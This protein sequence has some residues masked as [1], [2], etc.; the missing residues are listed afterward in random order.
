MNL[1]S[2]KI[3]FQNQFSSIPRYKEEARNPEFQ[4]GQ[5]LNL[6]FNLITKGDKVLY[7][8][9]TTKVKIKDSK[10]SK[11]LGCNCYTIIMLDT[12]GQIEKFTTEE[13]L[14]DL[15]IN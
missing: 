2:L 15:V 9:G 5:E 12:V 13:E 6:V 14:K 1:S 3:K 11:S 8:Y 4:N 10:Y 7:N